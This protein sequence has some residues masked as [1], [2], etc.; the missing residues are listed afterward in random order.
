MQQKNP[1][2]LQKPRQGLTRERIRSVHKE[3]RSKCFPFIQTIINNYD[4]NKMNTSHLSPMPDGHW[5]LIFTF[6]H[7]EKCLPPVKSTDLR[8]A[9]LTYTEKSCGTM[10]TPIYNPIVTDENQ[11]LKSIR[12]RH[13]DSERCVQL[14]LFFFVF[15]KVPSSASEA[16]SDCRLYLRRNTYKFVKNVQKETLAFNSIL[17]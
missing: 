12:L 11:H 8:T 2:A 1:Q 13:S 9:V 5:V 4:I 16:W 3:I 6:R 15:G 17:L 7:Y 10:T 14:G